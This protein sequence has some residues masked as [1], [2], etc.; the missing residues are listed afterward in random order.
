MPSTRG[1]RSTMSLESVMV[2]LFRLQ[3]RRKQFPEYDLMEFFKG[4]AVL[5]DFGAE[6]R[7]LPGV[8]QKGRDNRR[9]TIRADLAFPLS[10]SNAGL[11]GFGPSGEHCSEAAAHELAL[12]RELRTQI[13][14]QAAAGIGALR[15]VRGHCSKIAAE[16]FARPNIRLHEQAQ[17][18]A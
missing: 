4:R 14:D 9:V 7:A 5:F 11:D 2:F 15:H 6:H 17:Q 13:A 16:P 3:D 12:I 1:R 8:D 18:G 10:F